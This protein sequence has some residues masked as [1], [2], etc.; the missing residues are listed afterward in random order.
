[1]SGVPDRTSADREIRIPDGKA[2]IAADYYPGVST[3]SCAL[4][5]PAMG[6]PRRFYAG[7]AASLADA[8][9]TTLAI[10]Y[11][12]P[13]DG[14]EAPSMVTWAHD[15]DAALGWLHAEHP[16]AQLGLVGHSCGG[17]L[18]MLA[19][20]AAGLSRWVH[21]AASL[22]HWRYWPRS[23]RIRMRAL[24][25]LLSLGD[26][27]A[28]GRHVGFKRPVPAGVT[29]QWARWAR[30]RRYLFDPALARETGGVQRVTASLLAYDFADD[31]YAPTAAVDALCR[32]IAPERLVRRHIAPADL[33]A[34]RIGHFG[35]FR[36]DVV[37]SLWRETANW[38]LGEHTEDTT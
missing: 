15:I 1:M 2:A 3:V 11:A 22:A 4:I 9:V 29:R 34:C 14:R 37:D 13:E 18:P 17:Q 28:G 24:V 10:D 21:V 6:V 8:G 26:D 30:R 35:F 12:R 32:E 33:N 20:R 5:A 23:A 7:F 27:F 25:P 38:L 19:P 31:N 36:T 16:R